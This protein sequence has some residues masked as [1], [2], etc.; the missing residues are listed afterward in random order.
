MNAA[1][2]KARALPGKQDHAPVQLLLQE[3]VK[4]ADYPGMGRLDAGLC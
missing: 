4:I 3:K 2:A 1:V